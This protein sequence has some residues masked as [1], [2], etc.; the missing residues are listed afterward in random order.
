MAPEKLSEALSALY[1]AFWV[2]SKAV[3]KAD[4]MRAILVK[5]LGEKLA[6]EV[7]ERVSRKNRMLRCC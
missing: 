2:E 6:Q 3:Q 7:V 4:V 1:Q 5:A